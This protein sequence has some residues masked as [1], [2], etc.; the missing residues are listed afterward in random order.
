MCAHH[1]GNGV[2][3]RYYFEW[4]TKKAKNNL[5]KHKTDFERASSIFL[6][7]R[8]ITIFDKEHSEEEE[9]WI[10]IGLDG[11][12]VLLVV[13]H[14]FQKIDGNRHKIRLISARKATKKETRQYEEE[15][16]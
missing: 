13:A 14:T 12:G 15:N 1:T 5:K 10:T 2:N 8:S 16:I 6:D 9:R 3:V 4:D 7:P 11:S